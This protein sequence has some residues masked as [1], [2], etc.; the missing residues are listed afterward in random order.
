[1][2]VLPDIKPTKEN[3]EEVYIN[4]YEYAKGLLDPS[5]PLVTNMS[6]FVALIHYTFKYHW[7]GFYMV[8]EEESDLI[9]YPFQGPV[10]CTKIGKGKGVCGTAWERSA[11]I[12]VPD[13][14]AFPG[15]I[16]CSSL[17]RSEIVVPLS[18]D[19]GKTVGVL[20]IDSAELNTFDEQDQKGLERLL[21][22]F[23]EVVY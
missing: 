22:L 18:D 13:V 4:L 15:H 8:N 11:T 19:K 12:I 6:N 7:T 21:S 20:D 10:A 17:S 3:K 14:D 16:A 5:L 9:L 23:S 1:M 2:H